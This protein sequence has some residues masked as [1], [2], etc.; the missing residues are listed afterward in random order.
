[1]LVDMKRCALAGSAGLLA[2]ML[3]GCEAAKWTGKEKGRERQ[4]ASIIGKPAPEISGEDG[5]KRSFRLSDYRGKVVLL[6]FW[7]TW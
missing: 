6:D 1:M 7:A 2:L 4:A 5:D 3:A